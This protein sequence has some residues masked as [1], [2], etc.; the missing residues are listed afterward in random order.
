[1]LDAISISMNVLGIAQACTN[2]IQSVDLILRRYRNAPTK[3]QSLMSELRQVY[4]ALVH[5]QA[6]FYK[7]DPLA[8][9]LDAKIDLKNAMNSTLIGC[10]A[11]IRV[12]DQHIQ[13]L[14]IPTTE[15]VDWTSRQPF[16]PLD[17]G[18]IQGYITKIHAHLQGMSFIINCLQL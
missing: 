4:A 10:M 3:L 17:D 2:T 16:V 7:N 11:M 9:S 5:I 6:L 1:M 18:Q 8:N 12:I 15:I 14:D 13:R